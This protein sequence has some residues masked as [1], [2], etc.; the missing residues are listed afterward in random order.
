MWAQ[1]LLY[2]ASPIAIRVF[3]TIGLGIVTYVGFDTALTLVFNQIQTQFSAMPA[4][5]AGFVFLSGLP[6]GMAMILSAL[7]A[8]IALVQIQKIQLL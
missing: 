3:S 7:F 2:L 8:R 5:I 4:D 1:L 6:T